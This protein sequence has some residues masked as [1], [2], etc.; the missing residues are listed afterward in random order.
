MIFLKR[1]VK[2]STV[3]LAEND[4]TINN[5]TNKLIEN[6]KN[7][8][9]ESYNVKNL[10]AKK[11]KHV[12]TINL[13]RVM[14]MMMHHSVFFNFN[15]GYIELHSFFNIMFYYLKKGLRG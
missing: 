8:D 2:F 3:G 12:V 9:L 15:C 10:K 6:S 5:D 11:S 13:E 14:I 1:I 7:D 4:E